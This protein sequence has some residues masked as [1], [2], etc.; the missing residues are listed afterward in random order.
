MQYKNRPPEREKVQTSCGVRPSKEI[1]I[2]YTLDNQ[3]T[4]IN[5]YLIL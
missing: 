4:L 3:L 1:I 2:Q 5:N